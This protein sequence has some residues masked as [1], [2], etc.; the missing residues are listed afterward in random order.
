M[1]TLVAGV[2][3][4]VEMLATADSKLKAQVY[5]E[6]G[7]EVTYQ[8]NEGRAL[9][10]ARVGQCVSEDRLAQTHTGHWRLVA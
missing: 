9:V 4:A 1:R 8:P 10:S 7:I 3:D 5:A 2:R 6:L